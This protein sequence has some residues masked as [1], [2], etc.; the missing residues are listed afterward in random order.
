MARVTNK[1]LKEA[2]KLMVAEASA[3][4]AGYEAKILDNIAAAQCSG[5][6]TKVTGDDATLPDA[7]IKINDVIYNVEVKLNDHAQMGGGSIGWSTE[8]GFFPTG[9]PAAKEAVQPIVDMLN[10]GDGELQKSIQKFIMYL[11]QAGKS[12]GANEVTGFPMSGFLVKAWDAAKTIGFLKPLN[13]MIENDVT[14]II[15]HYARKGVSYIQIGGRGLFYLADNPAN[16]PIPQLHGRVVLEVR[17]G[18]SGSHGK[19][20]GASGQIRVQARLKIDGTSPYTLDDY[21]IVKK[22]CSPGEH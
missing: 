8:K 11:N 6:I 10:S 22:I 1:L 4:A 18:R 5:N 17:A 7:D 21:P 9:K 15:S 2:I 3:V 19:P 14:F 20:T 13:R 16:L 12:K